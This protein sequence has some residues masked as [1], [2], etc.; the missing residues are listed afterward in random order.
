MAVGLITLAIGLLVIGREI[1]DVHFL[2]IGLYVLVTLLM[3]VLAFHVSRSRQI[4]VAVAVLLSLANLIWNQDWPTTLASGLATAAFI[5]TFFSALSTLKFAAESSPS[6][7]RCGQFLSQQPPGR[8]YIALTVGGQLFGLLLNYGSISLLGSMSVSQAALERNEEIRKHRIRRMLLAI[9]RGFISILPW[10]PFSFAIAIPVALVPGATWATSAIPGLVSG[11][12]MALTG[13]LLDTVFKPKLKTPAPARPI[14]KNWNS[15]MPLVVLLL[16][17]ATMIGIAYQITGMRVV[18]LVTLIVPVI[19]LAWIAV[20]HLG[21]QSVVQV[22]Q[23]AANFLFVQLAD[24]RGEMILLIMAGY[25]GTIASPLLG[26]L[27]QTFSIDLTAIPA[28]SILVLIVWFIPLVGQIGM[29]P[30]LAA[31]LITPVL[32]NASALGV[33][34]ASIVM[35]ITAGWI[36]SGVSS[37]FTA[38]TLLVGKFGNVSSHHVGTRWNGSYTLLC[39]TL[40]SVWVAVYSGLG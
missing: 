12:I 31:T 23:R 16:L 21:D 38:T 34:P 2:D 17:L 27:I 32:P 9:Q 5:S 26:A 11:A 28:W 4:F 7:R 37:P 22:R 30:I 29:N 14:D 36:L 10:S 20:Q 8:R 40:L 15:I 33:T 13:W 35:A 19:S 39:A 6:I 18:I 3:I 1:F 25:L 24:F